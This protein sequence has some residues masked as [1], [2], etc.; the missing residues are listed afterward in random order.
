MAEFTKTYEKNLTAL[1]KS[2][3]WNMEGEEFNLGMEEYFQE[4]WAF[5]WNGDV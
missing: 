4:L 2:L 1:L 3:G 5:G